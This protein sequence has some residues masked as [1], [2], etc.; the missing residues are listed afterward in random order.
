[1]EGEVIDV[2]V[3]VDV[4]PECEVALPVGEKYWHAFPTKGAGMP[5]VDLRVQ[6]DTSSILMPTNASV[7]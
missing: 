4:V 2:Q 3:A 7:N 1:M 5:G 6:G